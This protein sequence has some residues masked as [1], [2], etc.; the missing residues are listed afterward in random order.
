MEDCVARHYEKSG[1]FTVKSAYQLAM[2]LKGIGPQTSSSST[3]IDD[4]S[5]W[6][7]IWKAKVPGKVR[8]FGWR[9]AT[10]TL[11][12]KENKWKRTL[13]LDA[14]CN[15]CGNGTE[16]EHHAV[17]M[18]TKSKPLREA[19]RKVWNLPNEN[20]FWYTG[21]NWLQTVLD[22]ENEEMRAKILLLL[23]RYWHHREDC[24]R[25]NGR[26]TRKGYV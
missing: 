7:L 15:I 25:N 16:T 5:L 18:C 13:E 24:L 26:G 8:I 22:T 12:T 10:N 14:T 9:V 6:D 17:V 21:E 19:M 1:M 20:R 3:G 4:G 11:A 2:A 23:W